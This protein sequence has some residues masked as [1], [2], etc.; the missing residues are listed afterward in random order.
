MEFYSFIYNW[1][2]KNLADHVGCLVLIRPD[3]KDDEGLIQH[4]LTH[5][6]AKYKNIR[7]AYIKQIWNK[8][9]KLNRECEAYATQLLY[10]R[11]KITKY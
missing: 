1:M 5:T 11:T 4:E 9:H 2:V 6:L 10:V 7:L 8:N 3:Y